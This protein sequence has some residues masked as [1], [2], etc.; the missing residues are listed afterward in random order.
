MTDTTAGNEQ[1]NQPKDGS[2]EDV[3]GKN[4]LQAIR[5]FLHDR[6][7]ILDNA[8][9]E[10]SIKG[11]ERDIEFKGFNLWILIPA[12]LI[13]S[14][15]LNANSTAVVVG[16]MLI[17]PLM[18]PIMGIGLSVGINDFTM[19]KR[20]LRNLG[21][22][23]GVSIITS[24]LFFLIIPIN[25]ASSELLARVRPDI[26]DVL[27]GFFG[28]FAGI[29]AGSRKEKN[30]VIPGV[31]IA[32]ALM[33]PLCTA[34]Y[35][36]ATFELKYF[37]GAIYLFLINAFF[38]ALA[39]VLV[40]RYLRFPVKTFIDSSTETRAKRLLALTVLIMIIPASFI[41]YQV[42]VETIAMRNIELFVMENIDPYDDS[43]I[44]KKDIL[45]TDS[46]HYVNLV[47]FG[48]PIPAKTIQNWQKELSSKVE[49]AKL[50]IFQGTDKEALPEVTK[51]VDMYTATQEEIETKEELIIKLQNT[52]K[53]YEE[54]T[55]PNSLM[56]EIKVNYPEIAAVKMGRMVYTDFNG[57]ESR[58]EPNFFIAWQ[59]SLQD[60]VI[61]Q[62]SV[63]LQTW[64]SMRFR[65]D[66]ISV[67][68]LGK[69][70]PDKYLDTVL[71]E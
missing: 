66:S 50:R 43:E 7:S 63:Q 58:A 67:S 48:D 8:N 61:E 4:L 24:T 59:P 13:A 70:Y 22:A 12:I 53:A 23:V 62:R 60:S 25:D 31:A 10:E 40:V 47:M 41:F 71:A 51:L 17:S 46:V 39:T 54:T 52:I 64:L 6:L 69:I 5:A 68:S 36:I 20:G 56:V 49:E 14:I 38:I 65:G 9:P 33:P 42:V 16:A 30:N 57:N 55:L 37:F 1:Q 21:I 28:G 44:V 3:A 15:G 19:L 32:T 18:G 34:G 27:I 26:R 2:K 29:L 45:L 35:G 11:I